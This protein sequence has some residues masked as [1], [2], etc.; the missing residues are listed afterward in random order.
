MKLVQSSIR[1]PV[2]T[3]VGVTLVVLFGLISAFRLPVQLTPDVSQPVITVNT[4]W[5][6]ASPQ[7]IE[8][9]I[10]DEQEEQLKSVEGIDRMKSVSRDSIG[11]ISLHFKV[12]VDKDAATLNQ[13]DL[14]QHF[15]HHVYLVDDV[16]HDLD[17]AR[18]LR[19]RDRG[20]Q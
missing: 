2:S 5:P 16:L 11:E 12:G 10:V 15:E 1:Y 14:F 9:D 18:A 4:V 6:G 3:A 7:E 17:G 8:R 19:E 20:P 13:L